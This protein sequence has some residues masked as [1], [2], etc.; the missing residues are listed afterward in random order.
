MDPYPSTLLLLPLCGAA[1]RPP[2]AV[3]W[4]FH[5]SAR[6]QSPKESCFFTDPGPKWAGVPYPGSRLAEV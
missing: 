6:L 5:V 3:V 2:L 1:A 4:N